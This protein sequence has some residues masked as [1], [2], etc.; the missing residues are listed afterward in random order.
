[1]IYAYLLGMQFNLWIYTLSDTILYV[2]SLNKEMLENNLQYTL[3][4][5]KNGVLRVLW[6]SRGTKTGKMLTLAPKRYTAEF[7]MVAK[8][9]LWCI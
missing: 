4:L 2:I 9:I 7:C 8:V 3:N 6:Y 5:L 1:M